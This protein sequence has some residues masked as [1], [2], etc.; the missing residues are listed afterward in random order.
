MLSTLRNAWKVP[1]LRKRFYWTIFLVAIFRMGSHIPVPG[2]STDFLRQY[3]QSGN[4]MGFYDLISG[5]ALS[6]FSIFALGV[7]PYINASIITQLLTIAIPSLEQLSKEG[8]EGRKKIQNATRYVSIVIA[9]ILA[10][11]MYA[12]I[13]QTGATGSM[14]TAQMMVVILA[15]VVG[16]T[17]CMWL[18]DQITVKGFGNGVSILI[19][20]NIVSRLP[21]TIASV[22][23]LDIN[24]VEIALFLVF[25]LALLAGVIY[26]SL[27][28]RRIPVQYAG[29]AVGNK[30]MKGQS[31]HIPLSIVGSAV[32][33]IIFSMSVMQFLPTIAGF[34]PDKEWAVWVTSSPASIFNSKTWMYPV[35]YALLTIFFNWFYTQVTFK[36]DEMSENLHKSAGFIPGIRPGEPTTQY[37]ESILNRI[38]FIGGIFA[39]LLAVTPII[40]TNYTSFK[41][42]QFGGT[43]LLIVVSVALDFTRKLESQ[44]IMRHYK[45]FLK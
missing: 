28:E 42:I 43:A 15:L 37:F 23:S 41:E 14:K 34:F 44:M 32:I 1:E 10:F 31:T 13:A 6:R 8:E 9:V 22:M 35:V 21:M 29:K 16:S 5:G 27:A 11:G 30:M 40:V 12:T 2:I 25:A 26:F 17:F 3:T 36:P 39:A 7:M 18:G 38:S 24:V 19:F 20:V 33:A 4:L 45:G